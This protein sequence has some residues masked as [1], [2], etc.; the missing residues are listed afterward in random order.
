MNKNYEWIIRQLIVKLNQYLGHNE[1][2]NIIME[3]SIDSKN[4][5]IY[6]KEIKDTLNIMYQEII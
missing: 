4:K 6:N 3:I 5:N 2:E 1:I